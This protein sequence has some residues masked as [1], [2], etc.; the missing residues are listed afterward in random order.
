ML[1][2]HIPICYH[3]NIPLACALSPSC[4]ISSFPPSNA[5]FC[6]F[7]VECQSIFFRE[8]CLRGRWDVHLPLE[9]FTS[10][11]SSLLFAMLQCGMIWAEWYFCRPVSSDS[12][13]ERS[14]SRK[15]YRVHQDHSG[16][17]SV[18]SK[19]NV[20]RAAHFA[21][22]ILHIQQTLA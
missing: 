14:Y 2:Y 9:N 21:K 17:C 15:Q 11:F 20:M 3:S 1:L 12:M 5:P 19:E 22:W 6:S 7:G 8:W 4:V 10:V 13:S 18:E 16:A